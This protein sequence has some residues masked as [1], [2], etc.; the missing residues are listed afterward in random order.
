LFAKTT[1]KFETRYKFDEDAIYAKVIEVLSCW[2]DGLVEEF[3]PT[4]DVLMHKSKGTDPIH[5]SKWSEG[6]WSLI[7]N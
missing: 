3:K 6:N 7:H 2:G 5:W 1:D 4:C